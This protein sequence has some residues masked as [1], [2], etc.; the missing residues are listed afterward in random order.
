[1]KV[2]RHKGKPKAPAGAPPV[3]LD[4]RDAFAASF[5]F[6]EG[7]EI[8]P[9]HA[10]L[11]IPAHAKARYVD[12][13]SV[14]QL[15]D[16]YPEL[17]DQELTPVDIVDDGEKLTTVPDGSVDFIIANHFLEHCEDPIGTIGVHLR[18]LRPGGILFYAVPDKR[19]TFDFRRPSTPL[20]HMV[21]DHEEGPEGSR[22][23]HYD[24][25]ARL[26]SEEGPNGPAPAES[27][28]EESLDRRA[29]ELEAD[30]YSIHMHVWTQAE[31]LSLILHCRERYDEA[32]DIE[33]SARRSLE[34][35]VVLRKQGP[36]PPPQAADSWSADSAAEPQG[37]AGSERSVHEMA[38]SARWRLREGVRAARRA[39]RQPAPSDAD[40][41]GRI[42]ALDVRLLDE[43][44]SQTTPGD[45]QSL[46]AL[47][48]ACRSFPG[49]FSYLEIGSHRG[50]SLQALVRDPSCK[51]I[52]SID[53]RPER[54]A[55]ERGRDFVYRRNST[56][57]MLEEL[58]RLPG[59]ETGKIDAFEAGT[60]SLDP[61]S[62]GPAPALC[63]I[64]GEHTD[65]V[66]LRD[67][68]FCKAVLGDRGAIAFHDAQIVYRGV[69][70]FLGR[71]IEE[72]TAVHPFLLPDSIFVVE[73]GQ[74]LLQKSRQVQRRIER[75][76]EGFLFGLQFNDGF[77]SALNSPFA[78]A[79]RRAHLL[80]VRGVDDAER[81]AGEDS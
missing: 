28:S 66:A 48:A 74:P 52:V 67:A 79:L 14:E 56:E 2:G 10:P 7:I 6:G 27:H 18:K 75:N 60:E 38:T 5:L 77:R 44:E 53:A 1:M 46:L 43:I 64:D 15:R 51:R 8:G 40:I 62:L 33:A 57:G 16:D 30:K 19:F 31:F 24:E 11:A 55:D 59:A 22:R 69:S 76:W 41:G 25:W 71:L 29:E 73:L 21:T 42:E 81:I 78:R 39:L 58:S 37:G 35:L 20:Q 80:S 47:H 23:A 68:L 26:V 50:G 36:P 49:G 70:E 9:L 13:M 63:F 61:G 3:Y 72:G 4:A 65:G 12:R 45:R 17:A 32:F 34:F 54:Q